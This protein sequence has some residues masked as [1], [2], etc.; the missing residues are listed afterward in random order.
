M[1]VLEAVADRQAGW[2]VQSFWLRLVAGDALSAKSPLLPLPPSSGQ[3]DALLYLDLAEGQS[4]STNSILIAVGIALILLGLAKLRSGA[5]GFSLS[6]VGI[7]IGS[8]SNQ[9]NKVG[10]VAP[11]A[12]TKDQKPDWVGLAIAAIG[13]VTALVGLFKG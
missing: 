6:N 7:N 8:T 10:N 5:G 4:M 13:L 12:A 9:T 3:S 2:S 11:A 1:A